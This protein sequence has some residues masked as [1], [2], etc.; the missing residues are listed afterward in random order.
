MDRRE[1]EGSRSL[2]LAGVLCREKQFWEFL[3]DT[4]EI[5][6]ADEQSATEWMRGALGIQSRSEL[7]TNQAARDQLQE[8]NKAYQE[9]LQK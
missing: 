5:F 7:K 8:I 1:F 4:G 9:W 2:R 6:E 3:A